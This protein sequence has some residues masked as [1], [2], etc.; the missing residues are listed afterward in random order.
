MTRSIHRL[1]VLLLALPLLLA[2]C[3]QSPS[4]S[5]GAAPTAVQNTGPTADTAA[6]PT[7]DTAGASTAAPA[8]GEPVTLRL[9]YFPNLTHAVGVIGVGRGTF[10]DTLGSNVTLDV[11]TFNAGPALIEA[12]FAGEVDLGYIGPNPAINGYVRSRGEALRIIAGAS[13]GGA[14]FIVRPEANIKSAKDL[15]GKKIASPQKGGTQDV[16][17]RHY[18]AEN[19]LKTSE[20]GGTVQVLPTENPNILTL[21]QQGQLDGAWV[22]EPWATRLILEGKGEVFVDERTIWPEGKF[23]TTNVI[24]SKKFLDEHPDVVAKFLEAHVDTVEWI[25]ANKTEAKTII[26][27]EIERITTK[28]L[29]AEVLDKAFETTD[30][31]YDPLPATL[32][33][34]AED[35]FN[36]GFL[37]DTK[38]DLAGLYDLKPLNDVLTAKSLPLVQAP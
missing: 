4:G 12:L 28:G 9:A 3:G 1:W 30:I 23:V 18:I 37:G 31:T 11:K 8:T 26:N 7:A 35:A 13:S 29:P 24:V 15:E 20:E 5:Q 33:K 17:L 6:A 32:F 36:L 19:G 34:S 27:Q 22:P 21:F 38:P 14:S 16:A 10:K 2:A 25:N